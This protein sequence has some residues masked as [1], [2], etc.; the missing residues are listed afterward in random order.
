[1]NRDLAKILSKIEQEEKATVNG[2]E[3]DFD[4]DVTELD[5]V[6]QGN[7]FLENK[8]DS[9]TLSEDFNNNIVRIKSF[10]KVVTS[11]VKPPAFEIQAKSLAVSCLSIN[12]SFEDTL[13]QMKVIEK[14]KIVKIGKAYLPKQN[15]LIPSTAPHL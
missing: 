13:K 8:R 1:M 14:L 5:R 12:P 15:M 9:E 6:Y 10:S 7:C 11:I 4:M 3:P 2:R